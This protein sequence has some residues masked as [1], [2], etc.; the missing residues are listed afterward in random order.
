M[1]ENRLLSMYSDVDKTTRGNPMNENAM[2][3]IEEHI[4]ELADSAIKQAYWSALSSGSNVLEC[5]GG[6]MYEV[7]PDGTKREIKKVKPPV[8]VA[9]GQRLELP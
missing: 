5:S 1:L 8:A 3:H 6:V 4:P 7:S 9:I 2:Q